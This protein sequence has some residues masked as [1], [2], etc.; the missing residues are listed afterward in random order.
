MI[1]TLL[2]SSLFLTSSGLIGC[3]GDDT[4]AD[5]GG[6]DP[7]IPAGPV[8]SSTAPNDTMDVGYLDI[9][10][11]PFG[12][13]LH[14]DAGFK[15]VAR[16]N[17]TVA[18]TPRRHRMELDAAHPDS[19]RTVRNADRCT[20]VRTTGLVDADQHPDDDPALAYQTPV[21][22]GAGQALDV[23]VDGQ[24]TVSLEPARLG[25]YLGYATT[26]T[27]DTPP[28]T[29]ELTID[30]PGDEYPRFD[31]IRI[32]PVAPLMMTRPR[33]PEPID[34]STEYRWTRHSSASAASD[35]T[36]NGTSDT[37]IDPDAAES[38]AGADVLIRLVAHALQPGT[39]D[40]T[41]VHCV[42]AD[43]GSFSLPAAVS[44]ALG[45]RFHT[46]HYRL[47]REHRQILERAGAVLI[48]TRSS[49]G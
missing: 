34:A 8:D 38:A 7:S 14:I 43:D 40:T 1:R 30:I 10:D 41:T 45:T 33:W 39:V 5:P 32:P 25:P 46:R 12:R 15:R 22:L 37:D 9:Q 19:I 2:L 29:G 47:V 42:L 24:P 4:T 23:T 18:D 17:V 48:V 28:T 20:V 26:I 13:Y 21:G 6:M 27:F 44:E 31:T 16:T 35:G 11:R 49:E 3:G 36:S